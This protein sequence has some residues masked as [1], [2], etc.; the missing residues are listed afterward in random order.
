MLPRKT[1]VQVSDTRD[2]A[3]NTKARHRKTILIIIAAIPTL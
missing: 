1:T 3:I 2:D